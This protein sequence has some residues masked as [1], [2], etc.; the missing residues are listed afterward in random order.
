MIITP[1][2]GIGDLLIV[3]MKQISNNLDI[4]YI[5]INK[6]LILKYCENYEIKINFTINLIK[7]LFPNTKI[8]INNNSIVG[9]IGNRERSTFARMLNDTGLLS[10]N[11]I[12][13]LHDT[14]RSKAKAIFDYLRI[15]RD[16]IV[17]FTSSMTTITQI[18]R[19]LKNIVEEIIPP[20][21]GMMEGGRRKSRGGC[22]C[23]IPQTG[24]YRATKKDKKYFCF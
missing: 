4:D 8:Y 18:I 21:T 3:K 2:L 1:N 14:T 10:V 11:T 24:G 17:P 23:M 15:N 12:T 13:D 6:D 20:R 16:Q 5:N 9:N 22:G 19:R 7:L